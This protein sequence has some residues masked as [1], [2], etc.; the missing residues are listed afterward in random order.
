MTVQIGK[1]VQIE[2]E[3]ARLAAEASQADAPT[4]G[5][6]VE[7]PTQE[8]PA[9]EASPE[10]EKTSEEPK[11]EETTSEPEAPAYEANFRYKAY[12]EE[13]EFPE[14]LRSIVKDK[15]SEEQIR[16]LLCKADGFEPLKTKYEK[17]KDEREDFKAKL[18]GVHGEVQKLN[19]FLK[20]DRIAAYEMLGISREQLFDDITQLSKLEEMDPS[21][22]VAFDSRRKAISDSYEATNRTSQL[23]AQNRALMERQNQIE[24][25]MELNRPDVSQ[26]ASA[27][28]A[29]FGADAFR[30]KVIF[31]AANVWHQSGQTKNL[32]AAEAVGEI[33]H[34][35]STLGFSHNNN[36]LSS[37]SG[38]QSHSVGT[39]SR[40]PQQPPVIQRRETPKSLPNLGSG[41]SVSPTGKSISSIDDIKKL[42]NER[43]GS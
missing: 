37:Q 31:N 1:Y 14:F 26:I 27:Y 6:T 41:R 29:K 13:K 28:D 9:V 30:K 39:P 11:T 42:Y 2:E 19:H 12:G 15:E 34:E 38:A 33:V 43:Y 16:G 17:A 8:E 23:E 5:E 4:H 32:S 7:E 20:H 18:D 35:L 36:N 10:V 3:Q 21:E 40:P 25:N 24:L 22:R